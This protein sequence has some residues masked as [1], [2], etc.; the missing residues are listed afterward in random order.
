M[1][2]QRAPC[3]HEASSPAAEAS[4]NEPGGE[5]A[6]VVADPTFTRPPHAACDSCSNEGA[7]IADARPW[8]AAFA[9][10]RRVGV[11]K[12]SGKFAEEDVASFGRV[13]DVLLHTIGGRGIVATSPRVVD[14]LRR[15]KMEDDRAWVH[16]YR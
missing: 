9:R 3:Q 1:T 11:Q 16:R 4:A 12:V 7:R 8:G 5:P 13:F 6:L 10:V 15:R 14:S 2:A